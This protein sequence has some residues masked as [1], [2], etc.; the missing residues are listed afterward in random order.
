[1]GRR[2]DIGAHIGGGQLQGM[3]PGLCGRL[4]AP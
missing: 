1:M 4:L 3:G 2:G